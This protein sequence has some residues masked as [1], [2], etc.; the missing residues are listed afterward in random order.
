MPERATQDFDIAIRAEEAT[1]VRQRLKAA[2]FT[3]QG[4]LAIG[5]S[6]W[7]T[8]EGVVVDVVECHEPWFAQAVAEAQEN[9]DLQGLPVLP[10]PYLVL[11]KFQAGRVQDLADITRML[12]QAGEEILTSVRAVFT[13]W[14]PGET[15]DL[16]SLITLGW[17]EMGG[18]R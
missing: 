18:G 14:L 17:L 9:R 3:C 15:E 10:M 13:R 7:L 5:G 6:S 4:E 11:M 1:E 8:R 2:G 16:E 12:G